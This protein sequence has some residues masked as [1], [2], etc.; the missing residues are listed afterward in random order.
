MVVQSRSSARHIGTSAHRHIG[1]LVVVA[2]SR[3]D[4]NRPTRID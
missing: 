1:A 4:T 2:G 3:S